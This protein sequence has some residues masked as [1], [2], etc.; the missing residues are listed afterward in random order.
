MA[1]NDQEE[2]HTTNAFRKVGGYFL[3]KIFDHKM[4]QL[5]TMEN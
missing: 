5:A 2:I 4:Q 3:H 1:T